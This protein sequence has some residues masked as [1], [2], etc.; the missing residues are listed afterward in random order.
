MRIADKMAFEQV[1]NNVGKNRVELAQ[2]Q[3]QAAT[4]KRVVKPSDDPLAATRILT[5]RTEVLGNEQFIKN[6]NSAKSYLEYA[7]QSLGDLSDAL[8]RVK[9]LALGQANDASANSNSRRVVAAE[10]NQIYQQTVQIGNRKLADRFLFGGYKT[11]AAPFDFNGQYKGDSGDIMIQVNKDSFIAMNVPGNEVFLGEGIAKDGSIRPSRKT[12]TTTEQLEQSR[13]QE[14][15]ED[16]ARAS[17]AQEDPIPIRGPASVPQPPGGPHAPIQHNES[18]DDVGI[19]AGGSTAGTNVFKV[20]KDLEIGLNSDDKQTVQESLNR[21]DEALAQVILARSQI[22]SRIMALDNNLST[23]QK[24]T[25]DSKTA[26]SQLEDV[27]TFALVTDISKNQNTLQAT[28]A[29]SG[30][31]IQPSLL[32]F[33][34]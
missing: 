20:L 22:G 13:R 4:Q 23:L 32:D 1:N 21:V 28:L 33:L 11:T 16:A 10:I 7:D 15:Q 30:K 27:D 14:M 6:I 17:H 34:K 8:V 24:G 3:N 5:N 29:T 12:P 31:L 18:L 26:I 2:L 19:S 25:V 9:E